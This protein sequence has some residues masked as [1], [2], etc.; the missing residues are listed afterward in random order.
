M[1]HVT[2]S[3]VLS[4]LSA[5][6]Q[7][8]KYTI[9]WSGSSSSAL[10]V[11]LL[12]GSSRRDGP[13]AGFAISSMSCSSKHLIPGI[14]TCGPAS[15]SFSMGLASFLPRQ[16]STTFRGVSSGSYS[17]TSSVDVTSPG[18]PSTTV[19]ITPTCITF[20]LTCSS[21]L[22]HIDVLSAALDTGLA[23]SIIL[24]FFCLQYPK[25]GKIG[26]NNVLEWWGNTVFLNTAD[27]L[28][29]PLRMANGTF[30]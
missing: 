12:R 11:Q 14:E 29:T 6:S 17:N 15:P 9:T 22:T 3:G 16:L 28:A 4:V 30:G 24:I 7:M 19:R 20:I 21:C 8:A 26:E 18:G 2:F 13:T 27:A 25:D 5:N 23:C 1:T 10:L